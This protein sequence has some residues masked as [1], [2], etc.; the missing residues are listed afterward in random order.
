MIYDTIINSIHTRG[1]GI[2]SLHCGG[3]KTVISLYLI[4][5][6]KSLPTDSKK[7]ERAAAQHPDISREDLEDF[8]IQKYDSNCDLLFGIF[9]NDEHIGNIKLDPCY[10]PK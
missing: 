5:Q 10:M 7:L 8:V 4:S 6:L 1:G 9:Y 3:G 2:L